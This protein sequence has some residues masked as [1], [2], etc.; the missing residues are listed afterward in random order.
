ME[1]ERFPILEEKKMS[2][3]Y[4]TI[5]S[6]LPVAYFDHVKDN[7]PKNE[8]TTWED[9][10]DFLEAEARRELTHKEDAHLFSP[11]I[12][13]GKRCKEKRPSPR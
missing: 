4:T 5:L 11:T 8:T 3:D 1:V 13:G 2:Y 10:K 9:F 7:V 12:F 6:A